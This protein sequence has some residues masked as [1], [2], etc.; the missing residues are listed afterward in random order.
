MEELGREK[1]GACRGWWRGFGARALGKLE[2]LGREGAARERRRPHGRD[3]AVGL[4]PYLDAFFEALSGPGPVGLDDLRD[5]AHGASMQK[6]SIARC[7]MGRAAASSSFG[8]DSLGL[9][10]TSIVPGPQMAQSIPSLCNQPAS[11]AKETLPPG[12][13]PVAS[14]R[15]RWMGESS[16]RRRGGLSARIST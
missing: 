16:G 14:Q 1:K 6:C 2:E 4:D 10:A 11:V 3:P 7:R 5:G 8:I 15:K 9:W 13:G 12:A